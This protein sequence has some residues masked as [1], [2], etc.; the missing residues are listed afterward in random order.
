V[1]RNEGDCQ[2]APRIERG[3]AKQ[4]ETHGRRVK[5]IESLT[6]RPRVHGKVYKIIPRRGRDAVKKKE[7]QILEVTNQK[8]GGT[9]P[10]G[11]GAKNP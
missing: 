6:Q 11:R 8:G 9:M 5:G 7:N 10:Q 4:G 3:N 2:P 1:P